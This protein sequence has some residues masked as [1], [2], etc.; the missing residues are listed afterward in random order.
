MSVSPIS[1][2]PSDQRQQLLND[3]NYLNTAEI[4]SFCRGQS[5][6]YTIAIETNDGNRR[7]TGED[8]RKGVMLHRIR[9]FLQTGEVLGE[10]C[11]RATVVRFETLSTKPNPND[12]L[13]YGQYDKT[14][15]T[16]MNL[17]KDLTGG[18]F[19]DGAI[20]RILARE[21]WSRGE[22]PTFQEYAAAW[23]QAVDEHNHPNPEWAFLS[24]L[25]RGT[26]GPKWKK[27]RAKK[28]ANVMKILNQIAPI[29]E[30]AVDQKKT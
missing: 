27:L 30:C 16:I 13:F 12:R 20:A 17:L 9:H 23:L 22:A 15:H 28:S 21:F 1:S 10:T 19:R 26:A 18:G 8:D 29:V 5:I 2:L 25:A 7:K 24:D 3:L 6:P 11:F 14:N 4:K